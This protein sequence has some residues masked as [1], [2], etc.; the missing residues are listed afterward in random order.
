MYIT[1]FDSRDGSTRMK[2]DPTVIT[3]GKSV[4]H[5][6]LTSSDKCLPRLLTEVL[7]EYVSF[8][9]E[10]VIVSEPVVFLDQDPY[11]TRISR[12]EQKLRPE[13]S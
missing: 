9:P 10:Q 3:L 2:G 1:F 7:H 8:R 6:I 5:V 13:H 4:N 11:R 12:T